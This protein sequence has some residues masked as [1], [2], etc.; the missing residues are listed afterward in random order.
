MKS[1]AKQI[2]VEA[3]SGGDVSPKSMLSYPSPF[4]SARS[5]K[6]KSAI[7]TRPSA[8]QR[9]PED[10]GLRLEGNRGGIGKII[11]PSTDTGGAF[12]S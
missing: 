8:A 9:G 10:D 2:D 12:G 11:K 1:E 7:K 5:E 4:G 3:A 6:P